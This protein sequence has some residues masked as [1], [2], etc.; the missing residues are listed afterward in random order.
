MLD[1]DEGRTE[2]RFLIPLD[3]DLPLK[4][5]NGSLVERLS[6]L[7]TSNED[8]QD[9]LNQA[10]AR[11]SLLAV[12]TGGFYSSD[13]KVPEVR[14]VIPHGWRN[15]LSRPPK[16]PSWES[17]M[18]LI[19][20]LPLV[21]NIVSNYIETIAAKRKLFLAFQS[22]FGSPVEYDSLSY[23]NISFQFNDNKG[24]GL[25][26]IHFVVPDNFPTEKPTIQLQT[27]SYIK[28]GFPISKDITTSISQKGISYPYS[29]RW[30]P[31]EMAKRIG[32]YISEQL[33]EFAKTNK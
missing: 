33:V 4:L 10:S 32:K 6:I 30:G 22:C 25:Y 18:S 27:F 29:P 9:I 11:L 15:T 14:L 5:G 31:D 23:S 1:I 13:K 21:N 16:L 8:F 3:I 12:F 7:T 20:Y 24:V 28:D 17:N 26:L 2:F 19:E